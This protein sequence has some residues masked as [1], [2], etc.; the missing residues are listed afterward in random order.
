MKTVSTIKEMI[1]LTYLR[2]N[3]LSK[4]SGGEWRYWVSNM[5]IDQDS[6]DL[7]YPSPIYVK[8]S[9]ARGDNPDKSK[10]FIHNIKSY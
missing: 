9:N 2:N 5:W 1:E 10:N 6:F 8:P 3:V 7:L 4:L